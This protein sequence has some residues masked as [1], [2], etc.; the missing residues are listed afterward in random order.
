MANRYWVAGGSTLHNGTDTNNWSTTSGGASGAS[1]PTSSD[2]V[3]IDANSG[4]GAYQWTAAA[5][6]RSI[7]MTGFTGT[8]NMGGAVNVNIYGSM[9]LNASVTPSGTAF[10]TQT[11]AATSTGFTID[12]KGWPLGSVTFTGVGGGWTLNS[13]LQVGASGTAILTL[14]NG[15]LD[16][17]GKT[18]TAGGFNSN[19]TNTRVL[20]LGASALN[21]STTSPWNVNV[22]NL[23]VTANT[24]VV[25]CSANGASFITWQTFNWNGMSLVFTGGVANTGVTTNLTF[26]NFTF[27]GTAAK[28]NVLTLYG[29][30]TTTGT[31]TING[32]SVINRALVNTNILGTTRTVTAAAVS[33]SNVDFMDIA[34]AG[35]ASPFTG[36]SLGNALGN[37]GITFT[38]PVTRYGVV[39]GNWSSTATWSATSGGAGGVSVPL[40]HDTVI[41]DANSAAGTYTADMPRMC[42][43]LTCTGFTRT[44]ATTS[45][46]NTIFGSLTL[47]S[48]MTNSTGSAITLAGRSTHTITS[49][50]KTWGATFNINSFGGS[51]TFQ[52]AFTTTGALNHNNGGLDFNSQVIALLSFSSP[53]PTTRSLTGGTATINLTNTTASN[54]WIQVSSGLTQSM[55]NTNIVVA[56]AS[57]NQRDIVG[58]GNILGT[59]TYTVAG[60][61]GRLYIRGTGGDS[62]GAINFSDATNARTLRFQAGLTFTIRDGTKFNV[63]GTSGKLMS[64]ETQTAGVAA[65]LAFTTGIVSC[66][67][68]SVK[69]ITASITTP[70]YCGVNG[71]LV[72]GTTNWLASAPPVLSNADF[73]F[74]TA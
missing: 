65:T 22:T 9:T 11:F 74:S 46:A 28:T 4:S 37:S 1:V 66:D 55:T 13:A 59:L 35:A 54:L 6:M 20:T 51:Y 31:F 53:S 56:N 3:F 57:A 10:S 39:A 67:Y 29:N 69:D 44:L 71:V 58:N 70:A 42:A 41:L 52:D 49:A 14:T 12:T 50:G 60:S 21:L 18:V 38:T 2:D 15:T 5:V 25:T 72:S 47:G 36:T 61:T 26:A 7:D 40:C 68:L 63:N 32:N 23:T 45:T 43:D 16:T 62:F 24:S 33:L 19:N 8:F 64:I 27:T 17:N 48:G 34:G 30:I 73:F